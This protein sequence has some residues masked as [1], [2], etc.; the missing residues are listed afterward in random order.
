MIILKLNDVLVALSGLLIISGC[1]A[2][3]GTCA[4]VEDDTQVSSLF[5]IVVVVV[6]IDI[7]FH[8]IYITK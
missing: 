5:L 2:V 4:G 3:R 8:F 6:V 1:A 7:L